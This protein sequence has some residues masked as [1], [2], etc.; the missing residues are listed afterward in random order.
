M[1]LLGVLTDAFM[2]T[3]PVVVCALPQRV[4]AASK[5]TILP[6]KVLYHFYPIVW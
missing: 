5:V 2:P 4:F 1:Y 3:L 6:P